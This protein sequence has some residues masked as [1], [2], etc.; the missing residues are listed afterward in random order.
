MRSAKKF[1]DDEEEADGE[2][3][4]CVDADLAVVLLLAPRSGARD[5]DDFSTS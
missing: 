1:E 4:C 2:V 3:V 5:T